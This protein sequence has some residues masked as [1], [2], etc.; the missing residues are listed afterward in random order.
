M[1]WGWGFRNLD[2]CGDLSPSFLDLGIV[3]KVLNPSE[4]GLDIWFTAQSQHVDF[5]LLPCQTLPGLKLCESAWTSVARCLID[6]HMMMSHDSESCL[7]RSLP[8]GV[9]AGNDDTSLEQ[10]WKT[11]TSLL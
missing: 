2:A 8:Q 4:Q 3:V 1:S 7:H 11:G 10:E 9:P 5:E 6:L